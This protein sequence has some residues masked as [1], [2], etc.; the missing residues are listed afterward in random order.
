M[1]PFYP[2]LVSDKFTKTINFY[3]DF[4]G[5]APA[6]ERDGYALMQSQK[7]PEM[8]IGVFDCGHE[9]VSPLQSSSKGVIVNIVVDDVKEAYDNLYMEGLEMYKDLGKDINGMDHFIVFD[10]NGVLVNVHAPLASGY[11]A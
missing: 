9:C 7:N 6:I 8:C 1:A 4:F 3:E 5:F 11:A 2:T 10:P